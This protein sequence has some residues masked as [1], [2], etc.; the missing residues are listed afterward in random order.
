MAI[1]Y[2]VPENIFWKLNP[3][4]LEAWQRSYLFTE[5][6]RADERDYQA[7]LNG[8][9]VLAAIGAVL[10][11]KRSPYPEEP[12]SVI[13]RRDKQKAEDQAASA[14]FMAFA[15]AFNKGFKERAES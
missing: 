9:Y 5:Q 7:W 10:D 15:M 3:R 2:G 8:Q 6:K 13:E 11:G 14:N 4:R 12:F 1:R